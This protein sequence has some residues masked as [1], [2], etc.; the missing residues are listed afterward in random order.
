VLFNETTPF[1][2]AEPKDPTVTLT[3]ATPAAGGRP[4]DES[5][6]AAILE[7]T[8]EV[9]G[10]VGYDRLTIDAVATR[11]KASKA[12]VYRR[13]ADK[14]ALV[15]DAIGTTKPAAGPDGEPPCYWPDTGSLREDLL[16]G[17]RAFV[18]RLTSEEG[19]L[20]AAV[21]TA[22]MR[23]PELAAAMRATSYEDKRRSCRLLAERA[24]ARG[25]LTSTAGVDTFVEVLPA[26]MFNRLLL[27]GEPLDDDFVHHVVDD[28]ALPLLGFRQGVAP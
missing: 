21:M 19:A 14:A 6:D 4:R 18:A 11:A 17:A 15:V 7:A 3:A 28:I 8:L 2:I 25:E 22:S 13:Y 26:I 23:D 10:E 9:L 5:R 16:A 12:T 24:I 27:S 1:R 20:L